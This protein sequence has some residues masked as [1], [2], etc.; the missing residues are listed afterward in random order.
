VNR[1]A[2]VETKRSSEFPFNSRGGK[3]IWDG[4]HPISLA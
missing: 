2:L 3:R 1:Q 4:V